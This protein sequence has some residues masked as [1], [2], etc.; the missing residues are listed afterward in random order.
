MVL[1]SYQNTIS[2]LLT[3]KEE[4]SFLNIDLLTSPNVSSK[5]E[6]KWRKNIPSTVTASTIS[7]LFKT[8]EFSS[9]IINVLLGVL[10]ILP[11]ICH[12]LSGTGVRR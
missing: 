8:F 6:R 1:L 5:S 12:R 4:H 9:S 11:S 3:K 10:F 2:T 7:E